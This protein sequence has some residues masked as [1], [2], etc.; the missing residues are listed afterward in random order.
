MRVIY[1]DSAYSCAKGADALVIVTEWEQFRAL[2][3][4]TL[5]RVMVRPVV[6]DLRNIFRPE[7]MTG[8]GFVYTRL[9]GPTNSA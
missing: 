9:G 6:V 4:N 2:D 1:S 3:L 7:E 8:L 5:K